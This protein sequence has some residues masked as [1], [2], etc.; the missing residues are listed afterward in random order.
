MQDFAGGGT[1]RVAVRL[2]NQWAKAGRGVRIFCGS[3]EGPT[4]AMVDPSITVEQADPPLPRGPLSRIWLGFALARVAARV[5]ADVIWAPGNF[6]ILALAA[7]AL[8]NGSAAATFCKISNPLVRRDR[9]GPAAWLRRL[10]LKLLTARIDTLVAMS[11][12]LQKEAETLFARERVAS[13]WEP[14]FDSSVMRKDAIEREPGLVIAAGRLEP[15]KNFELAITAMAR[16]PA[17]SG[18][19]MIIL[20]EGSERPRLTQLIADLGLQKRVLL[21]GHVRDIRPWLRRAACFLMTSRYEGYPAALV[22]AVVSGA[23]VLV[24]PC[25]PALAEIVPADGQTQIVQADADA[26]AKALL[27]LIDRPYM[28]PDASPLMSR[29]DEHYCATSYLA[30]LDRR[31]AQKRGRPV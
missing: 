25:S 2:A 13:Q 18:I 12:A 7:F 4:R 31:L 29:H 19:R 23:P 20:G 21:A 22:E 9:R 17:A 8:R 3:E 27:E 28:P 30:L 16:L 1:E 10:T 5:Q 14:I 6:H 24:T 11:P 26:I 15:Q